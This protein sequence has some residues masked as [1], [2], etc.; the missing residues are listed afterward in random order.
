MKKIKRRSLS[1]IMKRRLLVALG[2]TCLCT[3]LLSF[4]HAVQAATVGQ[5]ATIADGAT[6]ETQSGVINA[7]LTA[8][9]YGSIT[10]GKNAVWRPVDSFSTGGVNYTFTINTTAPSIPITFTTGENSVIDFAHMRSAIPGWHYRGYVNLN[11]NNPANTVII[12]D[13]TTFRIGVG[14]SPD[15]ITIGN[16]TVQLPAGAP[17]SKA[18]VYVE[19]GTITGY[20]G[21]NTAVDWASNPAVVVYESAAGVYDNVIQLTTGNTAGADL[22]NVVGRPGFM[23]TPLTKYWVDF[24]IRQNGNSW[25]IGNIIA[26]NQSGSLS[27]SGLSAGDSQLAMRNLWRMDNISLRQRAADLR[28]SR[29]AAK[30]AGSDS[31]ATGSADDAVT[32]NIWANMTRGKYHFASSYGRDFTQ[33]YNALT[34]G[35]DKLREGDFYNGRLYQGVFLSLL[36]SDASYF[37]GKGDLESSSIGVYSNWL[38]NNNHFLDLALRFSKLDNK[39]HFTDTQSYQDARYGNRI[40]SVGAQYGRRQDLANGWFVEPSVGLNYG[41]MGKTDY[42]L[43]NGLSVHQGHVPML[44]GRLE[45]LAGRYTGG[46]DNPGS[47]YAK[48]SLNHDFT[49]GG[50]MI[51]TYGNASLPIKPVGK[52]TW[53]ELTLGANRQISDKSNAYVEFSKSVGGKVDTDWQVNAGMSWR[54]NGPSRPDQA[55]AMAAFNDNMQ[56]PAASATVGAGGAPQAIPAPVGTDVAAGAV[57]T[58]AD[59]TPVS[60]S[61]TM[62]AARTVTPAPANPAE[63]TGN[64]GQAGMIEQTAISQPR[65]AAAG[66]A[67]SSGQL[68]DGTEPGSYA[69]APLVVEAARPAWE[70]NLSPGTVS[71]VRPDDYK[72][73]MKTLPEL[74][75]TVPGVYIHKANGE[76]HYSVARVRGSTGGQVNIYVDGVLINSA[77]EVAVDLSI[78]PVENVERVEV[79]RGY[80][81]ARFSGAPLGGAINIVTKKPQQTGGS[82]TQGWRSFDGYTGNLELNMPLGEG[83]LLFGLNRDQARGDFKYRYVSLYGANNSYPNLDKWRRANEFR[84]T[85]ALL[86]WQDD[87][88]LVKAAYK[89]DMTGNVGPANY[90]GTDI[91]AYPGSPGHVYKNTRRMVIDDYSLLVGRRQTDG[92]LEWGWRL[93]YGYNKK[94]AYDPGEKTIWQP[95]GYHYSF[96]RNTRTGVVLDGS[97]KMGDS[98]LVEFYA[99]YA[100]E[101]MKTR[102][103][104]FW[105]PT[106]IT[107][108]DADYFIGEYDIKKYYFQLQDT[109]TL[110]K[111][112]NLKFVPLLRREK[113]TMTTNANDGDGKWRDSYNLALQ[114]D[115]ND[116]LTVRSSYG[117]YHRYPNFF[118]IF[119]DGYYVVTAPL[120]QQYGSKITVENGK[121]W[122]IGVNARGRALGAAT[123]TTLTY[124]NRDVHNLSSYA[125][126]PGGRLYY[127]NVGDGI[128]KGV[129]LEHSMKWKRWDLLAAVTRNHTEITGRGPQTFYSVGKR[130]VGIPQWESNI[131]LNYRFPG[132]KLSMFGE[133]HYVGETTQGRDATC[134]YEALGLFNAGVKYSASSSLDLSFGVNDIFN[135]G[136][137]QTFTT[138]SSGT[139]YTQN[140]TFPLQGRTYYMT[141][142]YLF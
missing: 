63:Q 66:S 136:P 106:L 112:R 33:S 77:S 118:E 123:D 141:A 108:V 113:Q 58:A 115:I 34:V 98:H 73:E 126:D 57:S 84:K 25:Q 4:P 52:D 19:V 35:F 18:T 93:D 8:A 51:G 29:A 124:F 46:K 78:I 103:S 56:P 17:Y 45:L 70:K 39:F 122:D 96:F 47:L 120:A 59:Q 1:A 127:V 111:S 15:R 138:H 110:N 55:A 37:R 80:V 114:K 26:T 32:E 10:I 90:I 3:A 101:N 68:A 85:D 107:M 12:A 40:W 117:T 83:S 94:H 27:E 67:L 81:P 125:V 91:D 49:D 75:Q 36:D 50:N 14:R 6:V 62:P 72:G 38:G 142:R 30:L 60:D 69:L 64:A 65:A 7:P 88:W 44:S 16:A 140:V 71:V 79:Y 28:Q 89:R 134:V 105:T 104:N 31:L 92:N 130:I 100:D 22:L 116:N 41:F 99:G 42:K 11:L 137:E 5:T 139:P 129:E 102:Y 119:G 86:K 23:D 74:L 133:Y 43:Q 132:E 61:L 121:Q 95:S 21:M 82:I 76:G 2:G 20:R 53:T 9:T 87:H 13:G 128:A 48:A 54:F 24:D 135:K 109:I 131:R 97:W